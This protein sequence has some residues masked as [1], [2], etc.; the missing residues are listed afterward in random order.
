MMVVMVNIM[1]QTFSYPVMIRI[2]P[3]EPVAAFNNG[4]A[5]WTAQDRH[6]AAQLRTE[7]PTTESGVCVLGGVLGLTMPLRYQRRLALVRVRIEELETSVCET[8]VAST[9]AREEL[10]DLYAEADFSRTARSLVSSPSEPKANDGSLVPAYSSLPLAS[11]NIARANAKLS[12][13][14]AASHF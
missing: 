10:Q 4:R 6:L 9:E 1:V 13:A 11:A 12:L 8:V 5:L 3:T 7:A 14:P 2:T